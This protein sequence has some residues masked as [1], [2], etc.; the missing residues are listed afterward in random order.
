M[1]EQR[2]FDAERFMQKPSD[3]FDIT[4]EERSHLLAD[5]SRPTNFYVKGEMGKSP[6]DFRELVEDGFGVGAEVHAYMVD[7]PSG[8][9]PYF[10]DFRGEIIAVREDA[11]QLRRFDSNSTAHVQ[12]DA[13]ERGFWNVRILKP[14]PG[15]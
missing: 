11:F 15:F 9:R 2:D 14:R 7:P 10:R 8:M 3:D 4:P 1:S 12:I 6:Q 5:K 13:V